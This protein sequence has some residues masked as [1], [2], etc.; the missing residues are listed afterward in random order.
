MSKLSS[1]QGKSQKFKIGEEELELYPLTLD[2]LDLF[3]VSDSDPIEKQSLAV[4]NIIRKVLKRS[5]PTESDEVIGNISAEHMQSL[6]EAI[7]TLHKIENK[8]ENIL[9]AIKARTAK[10]K[11]IEQ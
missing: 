10:A 1:L 3:A 11:T 7:T 9:D 6:M 8:R 2:E 5:Y 4:R